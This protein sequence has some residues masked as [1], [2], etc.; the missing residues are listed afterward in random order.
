MFL[1]LVCEKKWSKSQRDLKGVV[2]VTADTYQR[3]EVVSLKILERGSW[4]S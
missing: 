1:K 4:K 3:A 2:N